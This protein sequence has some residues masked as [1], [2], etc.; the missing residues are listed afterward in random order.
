MSNLQNSSNNQGYYY[1]SNNN[2]LGCTPSDTIWGFK[3]DTK[4]ATPTFSN[5]VW[6]ESGFNG[7]GTSEKWK[8][9]PDHSGHSSS[10]LS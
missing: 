10:L 4:P 7:V 1:P 2:G 3:P 8:S 6:S 5:G 9:N